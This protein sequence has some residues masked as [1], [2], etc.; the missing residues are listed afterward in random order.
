MKKEIRRG[1]KEGQK[2]ETKPETNSFLKAHREYANFILEQ[3]P[4]QEFIFLAKTNLILQ[5]GNISNSITAKSYVY[6]TYLK[7][8]QGDLLSSSHR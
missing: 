4:N 6:T 7:K 5:N 2:T 3:N 8:G 1:V